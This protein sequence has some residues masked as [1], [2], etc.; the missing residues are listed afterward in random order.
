MIVGTDTRRL[1]G[2]GCVTSVESLQL[3]DC[4]FLLCK[5]G[6]LIAPEC[7]QIIMGEEGDQSLERVWVGVGVRGLTIITP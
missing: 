3:S 5:M 1:S 6:Q 4:G 7:G 2:H